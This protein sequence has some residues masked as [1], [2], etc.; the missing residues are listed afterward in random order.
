MM[1]FLT[2]LS[3]IVILVSCRPAETIKGS[4]FTFN[5]PGGAPILPTMAATMTRT[6]PVASPEYIANATLQLTGVVEGETIKVYTNPTCTAEVGSVVA[7][8]T[9]VDITTIALPVISMSFYTK[10]I[11]QFTSTAC[12]S[13]MATYEYL[14]VKPTIATSMTLTN[15]G[16][17]PGSVATPTILLSG[18]VAGETIKI[19]IDAAC[20]TL[21][22][23]AVATGTTASITT[24]QLAP[25]V[26]TFYTKTTNI[27]STSLCS[28]ALLSYDYTGVAPV[29]ISSLARVDPTTNSDYD[30]TPTFL[31]TGSSNGDTVNLYTD[32]GCTTL[33]A[34]GN[35][36][37]STV[38]LT[39]SALSI[40]THNFYSKT[41]NVI[42]TSTCSSSLL[43]YTYLGAAPSVEIAWTANKEKAVNTTGGGYKIYYSKTTPVDITTSSF[44]DVPYV[45]G[46]SAPVTKIIST[47]TAGMTYFK[48]VAYSA[49]NAPGTS[50]GSKS[51]PSTQ[52][53]VSLP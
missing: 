4:A 42:G 46:A 44:V 33:V 53:S 8:A 21:Y 19:Y 7:S 49:L 41:T 1:K 2:L 24:N 13:A 38:S 36:V 34:T 52:F 5:K 22:G 10:S 25:G 11:N 28:T 45:S 3:F 50:T 32:S 37:T 48:V 18:V 27:Y 14:G 31:A 23:S 12:S 6:S 47:L 39:T 26:N 40:G 43:A 17:S 51:L 35:A 15:P 9:T 16:S 30:S 20:T 29:T